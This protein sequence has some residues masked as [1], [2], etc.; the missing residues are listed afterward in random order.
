M[1]FSF[2]PKGVGLNEDS[3]NRGKVKG[4]LSINKTSKALE[5]FDMRTIEPLRIKIGVKVNEM[6]MRCEFQPLRDG[7][8][9]PSQIEQRFHLVI[10][11]FDV[12]NQYFLATYSDYR[13]IPE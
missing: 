3:K 10:A 13:F 8:I 2:A 11:G 4:H 12:V 1:V 6:I 9:V 5:W 7:Q